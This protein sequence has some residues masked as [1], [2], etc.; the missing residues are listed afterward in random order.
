MAQDI[1]KLAAT[2]VATAR[3]GEMRDIRK[4]VRASFSQFIDVAL[5]E[6]KLKRPV[7]PGIFR[8]MIGD[9]NFVLE[10]ANTQREICLRNGQAGTAADLVGT[11][12]RG[13]FFRDVLGGL[14]AK[15]VAT[16]QS[17]VELICSL[18]PGHPGLAALDAAING[19]LNE[20]A[21]QEGLAYDLPVFKS[22]G[23]GLD[24]GQLKGHDPEV[25][26][27]Y[28]ALAEAERAALAPP[29]ES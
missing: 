9:D 11:P 19:G 1:A 23:L 24:Q 8:R 3:K 26:A 5:L 18:R 17:E 21:E 10:I 22:V 29:T 16:N 28:K 4:A 14:L 13:T 6:R 20:I 15:A 2:Q 25:M 12:A 27:A 7:N